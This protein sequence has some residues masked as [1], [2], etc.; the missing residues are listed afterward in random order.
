MKISE[1]DKNKIR[2]MRADGYIYREIKEK[3]GVSYASICRIIGRAYKTGVM[4]SENE[5]N[6]WVQY[7]KRNKINNDNYQPEYYT[8]LL[9]LFVR[10]QKCKCI[11]TES[12]VNYNIDIFLSK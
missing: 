12:S 6:Y 9:S 2:K 4:H 3:Y 7:E 11:N 8:R 5:D 1:S 10:Q